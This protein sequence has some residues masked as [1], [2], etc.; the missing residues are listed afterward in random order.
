MG[1]NSDSTLL[2]VRFDAEKLSLVVGLRLTPPIC[3]GEPWPHDW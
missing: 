3:G 2:S 1:D